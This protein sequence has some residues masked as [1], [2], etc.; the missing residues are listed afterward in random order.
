MDV[1]P[2]ETRASSSASRPLDLG[3]F[4]PGHILADR[5]RIVALLGRGGMGEVYR[6]DDLKLG[7]PVALKFL[8][9]ELEH[10]AAARDR[11]LAEVRS[12][13]TVSHPNVCRVYDV[14]DVGPST[15]PDGSREPRSG[16][17]RLF[18]T[19]E[20]IDGEDLATLLRRIGRLPAAKALEIAR[21]LCAGLAAAHDKGL[22]HRDLK[23]ANIMVDGRGQA[24]ITDF[25]LAISAGAAASPADVAGTLG[26]M[27]PE[28]FHGAPASV[29]SDLYGL[30]LIL[31][32]TYTGRPAFRADSV[33]EWERAHSDSTPAN[34]SALA[35]EVEPVVERAILRCLEK[36]PAKRPASAAQVAAALPGGDPLAAALAAGE[37]P[38]PELVAASGEEGTL[39]RVKAWVWLAACLAALVVVPFTLL[40]FSVIE[41]IPFDLGPGTLQVRARDI[42]ESLGYR[43]APA[44]SVW[45]FR[46]DNEYLDR[47]NRMRPSES[48]A[49]LWNAVP[50]PVRFRYRQSV[51]RLDPWHRGG[52]TPAGNPPPAP[53]DVLVETDLRGRLLALSV[54]PL[55][56]RATASSHNVDWP[57]LVAAARVGE[58]GSFIASES[59]WW[60]E[61]AADVR[62]AREGI[63]AGNRVRLEAAARGGLPVF[64]RLVLPWDKAPDAADAAASA[65][66]RAAVISGWIV[67]GATWIT[68][69]VLLVLVWR[70]LRLRRGDR[71]SAKW[72]GIVVGIATA[73]WEALSPTPPARDLDWAL[74]AGLGNG[75]LAW[76]LYLGLEPAVRRTWPQL[77]VTWT[78]LLNGQW[79][80]PLVGRALLA[81]VLGGSLYRMPGAQ[82][83]YRLLDLP[84][85][86]P[87]EWSGSLAGG[88]GFTAGA[89][90]ALLSGLMTAVIYLAILLILRLVLR[91]KSLAWVG[92]LLLG[93]AFGYFQA[94]SYRPTTIH[95]GAL[96]IFG[97]VF[98][99][100][101]IWVLWKHGALA[102][103]TLVFV[104]NLE[105]LA[106]W[107]LDLSRWYAWRQFVVMALVVAIAVW[108]FRNVLGKQSAFPSGALD[109]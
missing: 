94:R 40:P 70:N 101:I 66:A 64:F 46:V 42:V 51:T 12:A 8:P 103:G 27:A 53:G 98:A 82:P 75:F 41:H 100:L 83:V 54:M 10:D 57:A 88:W 55:P 45:W 59:R 2:S 71:V 38:S 58:P 7:Q 68:R 73:A 4:A 22:L 61:S 67:D 96:I 48:F 25:G 52:M 47:V 31:Y 86:G 1:G 17:G 44:D 85:G 5:Y 11:L 3:G 109:G 87:T 89:C 81:G 69:I 18:L 43:D 92:F 37:T 15:R 63:Y 36:D 30:G 97:F 14:G 84:G 24:R 72:L 33:R 39:V 80:D 20:Y 19:M 102:L 26:Y 29:Q 79:R 13:R 16:Q 9:A 107:T 32:E 60:P 77:L 105:L 104:S 95:P 99:A 106:P 108:G 74:V 49:E 35:A 23:P 76:I 28:R 90:E 21:Q 6:A 78:R 50:G 91:R 56:F 34:P 65:T 93:V 62:E